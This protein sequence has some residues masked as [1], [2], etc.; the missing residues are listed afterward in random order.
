MVFGT[1]A[2]ALQASV[3]CLSA[4]RSTAD[5]QNASRLQSSRN[6]IAEGS[7][8]AVFAARHHGGDRKESAVVRV[9]AK[10]RK[11]K[12][13]VETEYPWPDKFKGDEQDGYL[14]FLSRFKPLTQKPRPVTLP[15]ERPLVDLEN[16]IDEVC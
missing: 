1:G 15:F 9:S 10:I 3:S 8:Q 5:L 13:S 14:K 4:A 12:K 7:G 2:V 11:G 16:K 6:G